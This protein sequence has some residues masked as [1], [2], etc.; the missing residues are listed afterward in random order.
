MC[1]GWGELT[2][3]VIEPA[4]SR[5]VSPH[6]PVLETPKLQHVLLDWKSA[7]I[8]PAHS[9]GISP[10]LLVL[11]NQKLQHVLLDWKTA[12]IEL[13]CSYRASPH[14]LMLVTPKLQHVLLT[15]L[16]DSWP[17]Y[18]PCYSSMSIFCW[19]PF[20]TLS[21]RLIALTICSLTMCFW[22]DVQKDG[23]HN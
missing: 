5:D 7:T 23:S 3:C 13:A 10:H 11:A 2:P 19:A 20:P 9:R 15:G 8:E 12:S 21:P 4:C 16:E 14:L 17:L 1:P 22:R 6:L 18:H